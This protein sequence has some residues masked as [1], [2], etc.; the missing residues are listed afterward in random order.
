[1]SHDRRTFLKRSAAALS[2][3]AAAGCVPDAGREGARG[4]L[5]PALLRAVGDTVLPGEL[6]AGGREAA[7][8]AFERWAYAYEPVAELNHGY[9]TSEIRYG[10]PDPV[11]AWS[12]QLQAL[13]LEARRRHGSG[14]A[15]LASSD[16]E[17]LVRTHLSGAGDGLPDPLRAEHV[18]L[19]LLAHWL[20]SSEALDRCYGR[21]IGLQQCR[22]LD[23]ASAEPEAL[24]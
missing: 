17:R 8:R 4:A 21:R 22:G 14:L 20:G 19:A 5:D 23:S 13:D 1:M 12:A 24:A 9:G 7:V 18:A 2:V 11:P 10:P 16:R 15:A 3:T 6:E